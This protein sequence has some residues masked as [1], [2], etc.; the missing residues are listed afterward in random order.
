M[1][2]LSLIWGVCLALAVNEW[3]E[4]SPWAAQKIARWSA[5]LRYADSERAEVRAEELAAVIDGRPGKLFKLITA[6]CFAAAAIRMWAVRAVI[7]AW[8]AHTTADGSL[9][10]ITPAGQVTLRKAIAASMLTAITAFT[11]LQVTSAGTPATSADA[12]A[13]SLRSP[14]GSSAT[15][16]ATAHRTADGLWSIQLMVQGLKNLGPD[17]FYEG[18]YVPASQ[19]GHPDL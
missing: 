9:V 7:R 11:V 8:A 1:S 12:F 15:G 10:S 19:P 4:L 3:C 13:I 5:H 2:I 16:E 17:A 14:S 18:W 6:M